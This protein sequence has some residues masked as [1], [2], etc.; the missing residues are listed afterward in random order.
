MKGLFAST[1]RVG[2]QSV[3]DPPT[4][5]DS[6]TFIRKVGRV[7]LLAAIARNKTINPWTMVE[8]H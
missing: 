8:V 3:S 6:N 1:V 5:R 2:T 4:H 7:E